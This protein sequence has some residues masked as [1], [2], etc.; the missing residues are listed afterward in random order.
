[1]I[2]TEY[3]GYITIDLWEYALLFFYL[4]LLFIFFARRKNRRIKQHPEYKYFLWGLYAKVIGGIVFSLIYFFYYKGG[5]TITYYVSAMA[6]SNLAKSDPMAYLHVLFGANDAAHRQYFTVETGYPYSY[7]YHDARAFMVVRM[8]S[9]LIMLTFN[10]YLITTVLVSALS[11]SG[12]W[13]CYRTFVRYFPQLSGRFAFAFLFMPSCIFWGSAIL[14]DTFTFSATCW[15]VHCVDRYFF[16]RK[17]RASAMFG[18]LVS[19]WVLIAIKP[20]IFMVLFPLCLMWVLYFRLA[21]IRNLL[22]KYLLLPAGTV[23]FMALSFVVLNSLQSKLG[24]FSLDNAL[25]TILIAQQDMKREMEYGTNYFDLGPMDKSWTS[26]L[27]KFP[28]ATVA[29]LFR[30]FLWE[31]KNVVM[32]LAGLENTFIALLVL[33]VLV[34]S[35]IFHLTGA[36]T[37]NPLVLTSI[38]FA[39]FYSFVTGIT[40]P[41]FGALV[42]FKV[43]MLPLLVTGLYIMLFLLNERRRAIRAGRKF[44]FEDYAMGSA[45]VPDRKPGKR[46]RVI[47]PLAHA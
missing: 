8:I 29:T 38:M 5:D 30:P 14:K 7:V 20:Y 42:R 47:G 15:F 33:S 18:L 25:N 21:R 26:V 6:M 19:G 40:T 28:A 31:C 27:S 35:R 43:P 24:K 37:K 3:F 1:M 36:L 11:Y 22:I 9:P 2:L 13:K 34:R 41:N 17:G 44:R 32:V 4:V 10:S 23:M 16:E 45:H 12:I 39:L 46:A